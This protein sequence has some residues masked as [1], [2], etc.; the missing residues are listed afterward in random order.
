MFSTSYCRKSLSLLLLLLLSLFSKGSTAAFQKNALNWIVTPHD[1]LIVRRQR[2]RIMV[3]QCFFFSSFLSLSPPFSPPLLPPF[4]NS[5]QIKPNP[6]FPFYIDCRLASRPAQAQVGRE[7]TAYGTGFWPYQCL[8][9]SCL[10]FLFLPL[11]A[12]KVEP[13]AAKTCRR[14]PQQHS[15]LVD[16]TG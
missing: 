16:C 12:R 3:D 5:S 15:P 13:P 10:F 8:V 4:S 11:D 7:F 1:S 9:L 14:T 2:G 6:L